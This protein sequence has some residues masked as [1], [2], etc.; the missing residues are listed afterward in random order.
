M[1][2]S[3][4]ASEGWADAMSARG[5][6]DA[7]VVGSGPNGLAAAIT[8]ALEG[9][10]VAVFEAH[11]TVG[12]GMRSGEV[13]LPGFIHDICSTAHPLGVASPFFRTLP[14]KRYGL[15]WVQ[16][17]APLAHPLLAGAALLERSITRTAARLG[18]D[19][20]AWRRLMEPPARDWDAIAEAF[21]GPLRPIALAAHP[22]ALGRFGL[23]ALPSAS[24]LAR[25]LFRDDAARALFAGM[26]AHAMLPL[27]Q[28]PSAAFGLMLGVSGHVAGWPFARGGSQRIADAL[29]AYL[30]DLGGE[31]FTGAPIESLDTLPS[32]RAILCDVTPRQLLAIAGKRLPTGY[33]AALRRYRYG[34]GSFKIDYALDGP[35]PWSDPACLR[36]GTVHV[37]GTLEEIAAGERAVA[38]GETP[39]RPLTLVAQQSLFDP[40]RAPQGKQTLWAYCH[41]PN[42]SPVDMTERIEAQIERFAPGF[43]ERVLVRHVSGPADLER[44]NPNYVGGDIN[45][46]LQDFAQLFTRPTLSLDPYRTPVE[47]LYICSSSTPPGGG[48]HGMC[49]YWA[50]QDALAGPLR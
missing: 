18:R 42:G 23:R 48:V 13:T 28:P 46:G 16:P 17:P 45:G 2:G 34:P 10:S 19:G 7:V 31:I 21:L 1:A 40:T 24:L 9:R 50:A 43:R 22:V 26:A 3:R 39:E 6:Y 29:A 47:G 15:E 35:V 14:L 4:M 33:A 30:R 12:G 5:E 20:A 27:E 49:G 25:T 37:G 32:A 44:Y 36:A 38:R 11:D 41:V 8:L